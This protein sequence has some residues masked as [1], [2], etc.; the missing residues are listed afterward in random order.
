MRLKHIMVVIA[1]FTSM[2]LSAQSK[3]YSVYL[4]LLDDCVICQSYTPELI[5]LDSIYNSSFDFVGYFPNF[6]SKKE[7]I[8]AFKEKYAIPFEL[9]TDYFK[10]LVKKYEISVTPEVVVVDNSS[11]EVLYKGRI[12]DEFVQIGKRRRVILN[13]DLENAL[14]DIQ[15][16]RKVAVNETVAV[17]CFINFNDLKVK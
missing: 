14:K 15:A 17:G 9:K 6:V 7:K 12:D 13:K 16:G 4:F 1:I 8:T 5:R 10:T 11:E 2:L 3:P